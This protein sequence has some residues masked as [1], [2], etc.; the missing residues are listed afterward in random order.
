MPLPWI[1]L[2]N[3]LPQNP[4]ILHLV[5][6]KQYQAAFAYVCALTYSGYTGSDGFIPRAALRFVHARQRDAQAL[7]DV[8]LWTECAGGWNIHGWGDFQATSEE[9]TKRREKAQKAAAIR[10]SKTKTSQID[11]VL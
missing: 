2:E 11:N 9:N 5:D 10:W 6:D 3:N 7:V 4:K 1:R 8:G